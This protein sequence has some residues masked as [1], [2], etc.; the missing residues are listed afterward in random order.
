MCD[1]VHEISGGTASV[2]SPDVDMGNGRD[3]EI[4][5]LLARAM[6]QPGVAEAMAVFNETQQATAAAQET[7]KS[8]Q[9][10]WCYQST[11]TSS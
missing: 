3:K 8:L 7:Y 2:S 10:R 11:N 1:T 9:P 4:E 6:E 5:E